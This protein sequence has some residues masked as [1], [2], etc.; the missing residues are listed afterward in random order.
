MKIEL[1]NSIFITQNSKN[2]GPTEEMLV[3]TKFS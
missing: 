3:W 2:V 1:Y